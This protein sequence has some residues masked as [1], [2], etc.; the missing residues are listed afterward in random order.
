VPIREEPVN[1]TEVM[2][3]ARS[4]RPDVM[5]SEA[6]L[7]ALLA[8]GAR[9]EES[10]STVET[11]KADPL[12][13]LRELFA[14]KL[15]PVIDDLSKKY[16]AS[17]VTLQL[18]ADKFLSGGRSLSIIIE[19]AGQGTRL[20]GTVISGSIAFQQ[21]RY[22]K[23]D[24]SGLTGSGPTLRT[25]DLDADIFRAFMCDRIAALVRSVLKQLV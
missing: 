6:R 15:T 21:T 12:A 24:R 1:L 8:Q 20:D 17:G 2:R 13:Q 14:N 11:P 7:D 10:E 22:L 5:D 16:G 23:S 3:Q 4:E 25:R 18:E 19:F 9:G